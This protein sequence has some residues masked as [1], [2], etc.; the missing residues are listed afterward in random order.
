MR[1]YSSAMVVMSVPLASVSLPELMA[2]V[3]AACRWAVRCAEAH[4]TTSA[5]PDKVPVTVAWTGAPARSIAAA[6]ASDAPRSELG[7]DR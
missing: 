2:S 7:H 6:T 1:A 5:G 4:K 3:K